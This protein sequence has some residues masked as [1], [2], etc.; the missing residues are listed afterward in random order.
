M[1][2]E[3]DLRSRRGLPHRGAAVVHVGRAVDRLAD[4]VE[5]RRVGV[6]RA[7]DLGVEPRQVLVAVLRHGRGR[8]VPVVELA[9]RTQSRAVRRDLVRAIPAREVRRARGRV[10]RAVVA[11]QRLARVGDA[12]RAVAGDRRRD[13]IDR[14]VSRRELLD[15]NLAVGDAVV[16]A[17][18]LQ[19]EVPLRELARH[20]RRI[21]GARGDLRDRVVELVDHLAVDQDRV[22]LADRADLELVPHALLEA[23]VSPRLLRVEVA[24]AVDR[25]GLDRIGAAGARVV[26]GQRLVDLDLM[27]AVD[28]RPVLVVEGVAVGRQR[29]AVEAVDVIDAGRRCCGRAQ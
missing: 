14:N 19:A 4:V 25:A 17:V 3:H 12:A 29:V 27:A 22:L 23:L 24:E 9:R 8:R 6:A 26:A 1:S 16:A 2:R 7:D 18:G 11:G 20:R 15:L 28:L 10:P 21:A 5:R 13:R